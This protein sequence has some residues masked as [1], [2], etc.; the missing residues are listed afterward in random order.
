MKLAHYPNGGPLYWHFEVGQVKPA[1]EAY[2]HHLLEGKPAPS[3]QE[4][5]R[6]QEY[7]E[8]WINAP[9]WDANTCWDSNT[10]T[11]DQGKANLTE[12]RERVKTIASV[13]GIRRWTE[14]A[15]EFGLDPI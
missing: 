8:Y 14:E 7:L 12:L 4:I 13:E 1:V 15:A 10:Y 6:I 9:C 2:L 5:S 3:A 11:S